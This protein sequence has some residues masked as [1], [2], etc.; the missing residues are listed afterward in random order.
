MILE[1]TGFLEDFSEHEAF[2]FY[3]IEQCRQQ[4]KGESEKNRH[5][6]DS[7]G[8]IQIRLSSEDLPAQPGELQWHHQFKVWWC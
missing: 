6:G 4:T 8:Q 2:C 1:E 5:R 7:I 3:L